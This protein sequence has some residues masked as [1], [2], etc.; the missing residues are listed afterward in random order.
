MKNLSSEDRAAFDGLLHFF[1]YGKSALT[2]NGTHFETEFLNMM[3]F[4]SG[5]SDFLNGRFQDD[6]CMYLL[7]QA[8]AE[9]IKTHPHMAPKFFYAYSELMELLVNL[10]Q[11]SG[12]VAQAAETTM[13][14][15][16]VVDYYESD[17][18]AEEKHRLFQ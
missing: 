12:H 8:F 10:Y 7:Q 6:G 9:I 17:T 2:A 18:V 11:H 16:N 1:N 3:E 4:Y 13:I 15:G 14:L 5:V